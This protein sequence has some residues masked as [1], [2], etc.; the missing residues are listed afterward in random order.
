MNELEKV[1][2]LARS[3][4]SQG[5][6]QNVAMIEN[7]VCAGAALVLGWKEVRGIPKT[8]QEFQA[9]TLYHQMVEVFLAAIREMFPD[10]GS[11]DIPHWNDMQVRTKQEVIDTFDRALKIAERDDVRKSVLVMLVEDLDKLV[12]GDTIGVVV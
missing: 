7:R 1:L 5:W 12:A 10:S 3:H 8:T 2:V 9:D 6:C 4:V 11:Y